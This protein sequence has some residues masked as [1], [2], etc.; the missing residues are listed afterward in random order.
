MPGDEL[1]VVDFSMEGARLSV[2]F[3]Q[4]VID[5][6]DDARLTIPLAEIGVLMLTHG[7][8]TT[9][10]AVLR[11]MMEAGGAVVVCDERFMPCGMMLPLAAHGTQTPRIL[12]QAEA[13]KPTRKRLWKQ[14]VQEKIRAQA[15]VLGLARGSS[16]G[17]GEM[18]KR[19]RS[20]D[21]E[22]VEAQAAARYW[23]RL[24]GDVN[25]RRRRDADD[26]NKLLNY[27]YAVIRAAM[28]RAI[29][30]A[31]LHPTLGI[32]HHARGNAWC[33]ADDLMEPYRALVDEVVVELVGLY[34]DSGPLDKEAK[35]R[36]AGLLVMPLMCDGEGRTVQE[37]MS[38]VAGSLVRVYLGEGERLEY[39]EG[40]TRA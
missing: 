11:G 9:T 33:L 23:P 29:C 22:N 30:A 16:M 10:Q 14:V 7:R 38:R 40:L 18:A 13:S 4:L 31:G 24:F 20:G 28:G 32:H 8:V 35:G 6:D 21:P 39:P 26:Q 12:A 15:L 3:G 34:G 27:G 36:L 2:R 19:V 17:L 37:T 25:F 1:R 5:T